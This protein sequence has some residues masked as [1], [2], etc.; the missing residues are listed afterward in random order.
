MV[1]ADTGSRET[2]ARYADLPGRGS[3]LWSVYCWIGVV[4]GLLISTALAIPIGGV[5]A[6]F[7]DRERRVAHR[8][9]GVGHAFIRWTLFRFTSS[10]TGIENLPAGACILAGNHESLSDIVYLYR[11]PFHVKWLVKKEFL[12][13]PLF[14]MAIRLASYPVVD[15]GD[16]DSA[17]ALLEEVGGHLAAG[18]PIVSFPEGTRSPDGA[19]RPFQSGTVRI[20]VANQVPLV[21]FGLAGSGYLLPSGS[22]VF[23][24]RAH[25]AIHI[26]QPISTAGATRKDVRRLN[27]ELRQAII[28][29]RGKAG[30]AVEATR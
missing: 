3:R 7:G 29:A 26:G 21:P 24:R 4:A 20:A 14:G 10:L 8:M 30:E 5:A 11:L 13:I 6:L 19:L 22:K 27:R 18:V 25:V 17:V 15:R 28:E 16:P 23:A 2:P 9:L 1:G 12:R